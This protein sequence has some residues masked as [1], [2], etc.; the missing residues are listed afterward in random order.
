[1]FFTLS[2]TMQVDNVSCNCYNLPLA[3]AQQSGCVVLKT[4]PFTSLMSSFL[5]CVFFLVPLGWIDADRAQKH[6][7]DEFISANPCSYDHASLFEMLQ[8][9]T[10]DHRLNDTFCCLVSVALPGKSFPGKAEWAGFIY[11]VGVFFLV[12]WYAVLWS[13]CVFV[14]CRDGSAQAKCLSWMST[15]RGTEFEVVTDIWV[16][17]VIYWKGQK[18][19]LSLTPLFF[20]TASLFVHPMFMGTGV[21]SSLLLYC[22]DIN[23]NIHQVCLKVS[24]GCRATVLYHNCFSFCLRELDEQKI[25]I[26]FCLVLNVLIYTLTRFC[27]TG[28]FTTD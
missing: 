15:V 21:L 19:E 23:S 9:L 20:T 16:T 14:L 12:C 24:V 4:L 10:L 27:I 28:L 11:F 2:N 5:N 18:M 17:C 1:M 25:G 26:S 8:R 7:M 13:P 22:W 3:V 6:G